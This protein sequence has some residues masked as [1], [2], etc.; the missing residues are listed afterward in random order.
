M[1]ATTPL[2]NRTQNIIIDFVEKDNVIDN[3]YNLE[4]DILILL[5][6]NK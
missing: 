6:D 5:L 2:Q 1:L 3:Q 4:F